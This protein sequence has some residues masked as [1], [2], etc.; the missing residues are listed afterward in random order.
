MARTANYVTVEEALVTSADK[1]ATN[2]IV[3]VI[4]RVLLPPK[5]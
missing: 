5:Q 3:H 1:T 2:G 4:D